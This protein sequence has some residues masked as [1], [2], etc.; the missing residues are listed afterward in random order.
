[1]WD[2]SIDGYCSAVLGRKAAK[3]CKIGRVVY[4]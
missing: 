1:M 3:L 4:K 2:L